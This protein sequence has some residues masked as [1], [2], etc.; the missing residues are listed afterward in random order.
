MKTEHPSLLPPLPQSDLWGGPTIA[1]LSSGEAGANRTAKGGEQGRGGGANDWFPGIKK[2]PSS[3]LSLGFLGALGKKGIS[4]SRMPGGQKGVVRRGNANK[5][6]KRE[7]ENTNMGNASLR[8]LLKKKVR[9]SLNNKRSL[10][11]YI[12]RALDAPSEVT[13]QLARDRGHQRKR[14]GVEGE[15]EKAEE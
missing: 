7:R 9:S 1:F 3:A 2:G 13:S 6:Q 12:S 4:S 14:R 15:K 5:I 8:G 11:N 10:L